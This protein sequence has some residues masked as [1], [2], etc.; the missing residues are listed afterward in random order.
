MVWDT[1]RIN[2]DLH[3]GNSPQKTL[4]HGLCVTC[5]ISKQRLELLLAF[6]KNIIK[7]KSLFLAS[8]KHIIYYV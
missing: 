4:Y 7:N 8:N 6:K 1:G 3:Y 5:K 2:K